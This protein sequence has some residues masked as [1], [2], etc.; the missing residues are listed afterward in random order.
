MQLQKNRRF[1]LN[2]LKELPSR[3][4]HEE[5]HP[6]KKQIKFYSFIHQACLHIKGE[7]F[8]N[9]YEANTLTISLSMDSEFQDTGSYNSAKPQGPAMNFDLRKWTWLLQLK[10]TSRRQ[11]IHN[12]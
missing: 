1:Y 10:Y 5:C 12:Y 8:S 4:H 9:K 7:I 2:G 11:E 3:K 6:Y